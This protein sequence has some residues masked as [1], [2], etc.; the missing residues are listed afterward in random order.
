MDKEEIK[1]YKPGDIIY[2]NLRSWG[3]KYYEDL[4]LP[5]YLY[6]TY[7]VKCKFGDFYNINL[8]Y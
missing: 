4:N 1:D 8:E 5:D 3:Y 2:L 6:T 7:V